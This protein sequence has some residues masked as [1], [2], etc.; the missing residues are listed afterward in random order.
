MIGFDFFAMDGKGEKIYEERGTVSVRGDK[1]RMEIPDDLLVVSDGTVKWI[2]KPGAEELIIA[3]N[4]T[5]EPDVL[6]NPFSILEQAAR[7]YNVTVGTGVKT[8]GGKSV[9][10]VTLTP[11][12]AKN[13]YNR[14]DIF[15]EKDK[16]IPVRIE[17]FSI[18]GSRYTASILSFEPLT[19]TSGALFVLDPSK[20]PDAVITDLR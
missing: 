11:R 8:L 15:L 10:T 6:E 19:D 4:N 18:D 16:N 1:F 17:F 7:F 12:E 20:Y 3:E 13:N 2:Y 5:E 14:I 9:K